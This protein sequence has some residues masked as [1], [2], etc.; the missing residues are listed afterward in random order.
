MATIELDPNNIPKHIAFIID[1]NGRW[2]TARGKSRSY[3]HKMGVKAL[4]QAIASARKLGVK[5][6]SV[7]AFSTENWKRPKAEVDYLFSLFA[8]S[9]KKILKKNNFNNGIRYQ[10]MG[11]SSKLPEHLQDLAKQ[12]I[13]KSAHN[14]DFVVNLGINYGGRDELVRAF[15]KM[16]QKGMTNISIADIQNHLDTNCL[17]DP[18]LIIRTG[19]EQRISNFMLFQMAYS[20][21]YFTKTYWPDFDEKELIKA[22]VD[23]QNRNRR[24]GGLED[25]K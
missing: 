16:A 10:H 2:A 25:K 7:Y 6:V 24:F 22:F 17:P 13:E 1:G 14:N 5:I 12:V 8:S 19:G 23:Y 15:N 18:E 21:F 20:E 4:E 11:D 9:A 3:G